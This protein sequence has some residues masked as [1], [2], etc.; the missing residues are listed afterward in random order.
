MNGNSFDNLATYGAKNDTFTR[1]GT[2][3]AA[4]VSAQKERKTVKAALASLH[5]HAR[6]EQT[7]FR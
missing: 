5:N 7:R 3:A 4:P 2:E 1:T 6:A